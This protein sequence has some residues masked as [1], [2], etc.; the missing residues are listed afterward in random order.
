MKAL[1]MSMPIKEVEMVTFTFSG[2]KANHDPTRHR[3]ELIRTG[4]DSDLYT[5][6]RIKILPILLSIPIKLT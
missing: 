5:N 3:L 2:E 4:K 6:I 1:S